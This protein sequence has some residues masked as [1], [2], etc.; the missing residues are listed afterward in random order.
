MVIGNGIDKGYRRMKVE[1]ERAAWNM[2]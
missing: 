2:K 1:N